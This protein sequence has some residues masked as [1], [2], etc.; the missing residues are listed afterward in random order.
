MNSFKTGRWI[1]I[2]PALL[3]AMFAM[4]NGSTS[5]YAAASPQ[6][7]TNHCSSLGTL[8]DSISIV[9]GGTTLG[10]LNI[11][12]NSSNGYNCAKTVAN[13]TTLKK[14]MG[15]GIVACKETHESDICTPVGDSKPYVDTDDGNYYEYAGPVGV[16]AKGHCIY[17]RGNIYGYSVHTPLAAIHCRYPLTKG[18]YAI[19]ASLICYSS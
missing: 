7:D 4:I 9:R 18:L 14:S 19:R 16:S 11:Y 6:T 10:Y 13:D 15:V 12:Y 2:I 17:A 5:A 8:V 1:L 3:I